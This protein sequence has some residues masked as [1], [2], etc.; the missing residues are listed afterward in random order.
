[1]TTTPPRTSMWPEPRA[2]QIQDGSRAVHQGDR[3]RGWNA[4]SY[5]VKAVTAH[6]QREVAGSWIPA[7]TPRKAADGP[8][9]RAT[10]SNR[11]ATQ[12][13][14]LRAGRDPRGRRGG[15]RGQRGSVLRSAGTQWRGQV[16]YYR[17]VDDSRA[18]HLR[19]SVGLWHRCPF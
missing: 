4:G 5:A 7:C 17:L 9:E 16:Y 18:S 19:S 10:H 6:A 11:G 8:Y 1:M 14:Q 13:L 3:S 2:P 12:D 15:P